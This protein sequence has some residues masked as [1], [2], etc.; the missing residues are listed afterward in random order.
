MSVCRLK[1]VNGSYGC[2][3][4]ASESGS[5]GNDDDEKL[6]GDAGE[7]DDGHGGAAEEWRDKKVH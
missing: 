2:F 1:S 5:G 6:E 4:A 3:T 7:G